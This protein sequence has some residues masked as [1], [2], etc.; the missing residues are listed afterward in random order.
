MIWNQ[1]N[2]S[3]KPWLLEKIKDGD[4]FLGGNLFQEN[5]DFMGIAHINNLNFYE[6]NLN[7]VVINDTCKIFNCSTVKIKTEKITKDEVKKTVLGKREFKKLTKEEVAN[8]LSDDKLNDLAFYKMNKME[9]ET[10]RINKSKHK[11]PPLLR[12]KNG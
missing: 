3:T 2:F 7:N 9:V 10:A 1:E 8:I 6:T 4:V 11:T 5:E 12:A